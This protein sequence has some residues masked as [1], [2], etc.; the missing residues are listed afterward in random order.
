MKH[1]RLKVCFFLFALSILSC[2]AETELSRPNILVIIADDLSYA[3]VGGLGNPVVNTPNIDRLMTEGTSFSHTYNMGGWNGAICTASRS[4]LIS[5][6]NLWQANGIKDRWA[7]SDSNSLAQTWGRIMAK[8][9]YDTYMSGKWHVN[10]PADFVFDTANNIRP[11]MPPDPWRHA[12]V[13][14][15][16]KA[17]MADGIEP[18]LSEIMPLGYNRPK[19]RADTSWTPFD[20]RHG[21]FWQ[22]GKHWSEVLK[23][24]AL[25]FIST[26]KDDPDP[27]LMY[28]AF[29]AP[30]DPRQA[31]KSFVD[32]YP[33]D[34]ISLPENWLGEYPWKDD[35]GNGPD[36]RDEALAPFPRTEYAIKVH[37]QE[38]YAIITHM[39][40]QIGLILDAL[41]ES[42]LSENTYVFFTADHGLAVGSH[43]LLG[44][45]NQY[46]HSVRVPLVM[47][48]PDIPI[49]TTNDADV[50]LQDIMPTSL[51]IAGIEKPEYVQFQSLLSLARNEKTG[52]S[53][54]SIYGAYVDLQRMIRKDGYKLIH[55][56]RI[57][58]S[59]LFD[60][61][62]D[63]LEMNDLAES[64][65]E[66]TKELFSEL[67]ELQSEMEDDLVLR[68]TN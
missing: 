24:D 43:G 57:N 35:I 47:K 55:Y 65:P 9:G 31:P 44:K 49:S 51:E 36:L 27:F 64:M 54:E 50:Y 42:G 45:Q 28:L 29:N 12:G 52:S 39:D 2:N 59:Q 56:S 17:A 66:K 10:A 32:Q 4:M 41:A 58:K 40:Y 25:D 19:S 67:V 48:G 34:D 26:A 14:Q 37:L 63:P 1:L 22:G 60:L 11:G 21:G 23:D 15:K 53:Y 62:E 5:G 3:A 16:L 18:D 8:N 61:N 68:S 30:H 13:G 20:K 46:D 38:Y 6:R 33:L 7:A